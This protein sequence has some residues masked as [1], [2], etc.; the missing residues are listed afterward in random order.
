MKIDN[1]Q[2]RGRRLDFLVWRL[3]TH[4]VT[5]YRYNHGRKLNDFVLNKR[6]DKIVAYDIIQAKTIPLEHIRY[7]EAPMGG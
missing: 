4:V 3:I 5:Y 1:H 7:H 2:L 6:V